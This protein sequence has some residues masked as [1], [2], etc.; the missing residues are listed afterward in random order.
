[1]SNGPVHV[2]LI[3]NRFGGWRIIFFFN[4]FNDFHDSLK[5]TVHPKNENLLKMFFLNSKE[6]YKMLLRS[7]SHKK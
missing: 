3:L 7:S 1:M 2:W 4:K 6:L 5:G